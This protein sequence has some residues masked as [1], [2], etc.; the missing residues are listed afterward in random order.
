M[1]LEHKLTE[2]DMLKEEVVALAEIVDDLKN[3]IH[4]KDKHIA[5]ISGVV[6]GMCLEKSDRGESN[7]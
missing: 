4:Q 6:V 5:Y 7:A 2:T 1:D 3:E